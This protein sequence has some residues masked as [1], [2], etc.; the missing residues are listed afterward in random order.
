MHEVLLSP[1]RDNAKSG[2]VFLPER[3]LERI[4]PS[5]SQQHRPKHFVPRLGR[6]VRVIGKCFRQRR[7]WLQP[8]ALLLIAPGLVRPRAFDIGEYLR[9]LVVR[10]HALKSGHVAHAAGDDG[11]QAFLGDQEKVAIGVVPSMSGCI[12]RR[13]R[14]AATRLRRLPV[15]FAFQSGAVAGRA[16]DGIKLL[17]AGDLRFRWCAQIEERETYHSN[18]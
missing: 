15:W 17:A 12:V 16:M 6:C 5:L 14:H 1:P 8:T 18:E 4:P 3:C 7:L 2:R 13:R 9:D 11:R 10:K